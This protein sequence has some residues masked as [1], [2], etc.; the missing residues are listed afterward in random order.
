L[1]NQYPLIWRL[2]LKESIFFF[3]NISWKVDLNLFQW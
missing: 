3:W 2:V 1:T